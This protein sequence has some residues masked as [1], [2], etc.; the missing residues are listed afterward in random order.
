MQDDSIRPD[1]P[2][3]RFTHTAGVV[4]A[5]GRSSRYGSNKALA[6]VDGV[7][8]IQ[9]VVGVLEPIFQ[10][11]YVITNSP[12]EY[13]FLGLPMFRDLIP[14]LGPLGGIHTALR[15]MPE[16][17][18]FFTAC[19]MPRL[20]GRLI[21]HMVD[22][23]RDVDAVVPRISGM[24]EALHAVYA[25]SCLPA[26]QALID[27][28]CRQVLR[29]FDSVTVRYL[30]AEE[31]RRYDPAL[32]SFFNINRPADMRAGPAAKKRG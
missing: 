8:L 11:V 13:E 23:A 27:S 7:P 5:G 29:F 12:A 6:V 16:A 31:I 9:R 1:S 28:R 15:R 14:G 10:R 25:R 22:Q 26:I 30:E 2:Q 19:D 18:G 17:R 24:L 20:N 3:D 4:L 21:R 32:E